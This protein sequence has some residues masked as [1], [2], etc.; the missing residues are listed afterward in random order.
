MR[1]TGLAGR[2]A[3]V[4][5][6]LVVEFFGYFPA[7]QRTDRR[8]HA[9]LF[10]LRLAFHR[11]FPVDMLQMIEL[12]IL[13]LSAANARLLSLSRLVAGRFLRNGN[14]A[15]VMTE[16]FDF[17]VLVLSADLAGIASLTVLRAGR[18]SDHFQ[19]P[20][21]V[22]KHVNRTPN[23]IAA[24][25]ASAFSGTFRGAGRLFGDNPR[26]NLMRQL[27]DITLFPVVAVAAVAEIKPFQSARR[28][29]LRLP[30]TENVVFAAIPIPRRLCLPEAV[31]TK[32]P[33]RPSAFFLS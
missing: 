28:F 9:H 5:R 29:P 3:L 1:I 33:N 21:F 6:S 16:L 27:V 20:V 26:L 13:R 10:T 17:F 15:P 7:A 8:S 11:I 32:E 14:L 23:Q 24:C 4:E 31:R 25:G 2:H 19:L 12:D 22:R 30:R 18:L